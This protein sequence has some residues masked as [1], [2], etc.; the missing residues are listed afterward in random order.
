MPTWD[1]HDCGVQAFWV[2]SQAPE[3]KDLMEKP[4]SAT[5]CPATGKKLRLKDCVAVKLT[6]V[7]EGEPGLYMDPITKDAFH[8]ASKLVVIGP[9]GTHAHGKAAAVHG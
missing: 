9:T 1:H 2:P 7:P 6:R 5:Y 3:S 4:D 8:N